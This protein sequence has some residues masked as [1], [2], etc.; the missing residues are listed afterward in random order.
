MKKIINPTGQY[1][2]KI[3]KGQRIRRVFPNKKGSKFN[4]VAE[5]HILQKIRIKD[6]KYKGS[7][8]EGAKIQWTDGS[9]SIEYI[10][11]PYIQPESAEP[12]NLNQLN[13][14]DPYSKDNGTQKCPYKK[15]SNKQFLKLALDSLE[16]KPKEIR[17][18]CL[19]GKKLQTAKMAL[20]FGIKK[21]QKEIYGEVFKGRHA[22]AITHKTHG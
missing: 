8:Y 13:T 5:G 4:I 10:P 18:L 19:D 2:T 1:L 21:K 15:Q 7:D 17:M 20:K 14:K 9:T 3:V 11:H 22:K 12:L 16:K 6:P